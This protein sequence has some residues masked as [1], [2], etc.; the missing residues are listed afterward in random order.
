MLLS[1]QAFMLVNN[2]GKHSLPKNPD[3]ARANDSWQDFSRANNSTSLPSSFDL[4]WAPMVVIAIR[5]WNST[6]FF[7]LTPNFAGWSLARPAKLFI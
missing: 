6:G 5:I 2:A 1:F 7:T 3:S 4:I